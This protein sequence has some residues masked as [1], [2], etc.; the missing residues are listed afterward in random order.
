MQYHICQ[1]NLLHGNVICQL[2]FVN[3]MLQFTV[4]IQ[5]NEKK[6]FFTLSTTPK[7]SDLEAIEFSLLDLSYSFSLLN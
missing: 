6:T 3:D 1:R 7:I 2:L 5:W 4:N